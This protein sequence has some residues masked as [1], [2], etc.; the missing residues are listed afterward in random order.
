MLNPE[1]YRLLYPYIHTGRIWFNHAATGPLSSRVTDAIKQLLLMKSES[2]IDNFFDFTKTYIETKKLIATLLNCSPE[3]I[4]F[5]DNTSNGLNILASGLDWKP[6]DRILLNTVEFPSNVYPFLNLKSK[7]VEIDFVAERNGK[8]EI[9]DIVKAITP[10]TRLLSISF[11]QFLNGFKA[12]MEELGALC[13]KKNVLFCTDAIQGLGAAPL[14]VQK[15]QVDFL[16]SGTHKW[17]MGLQGFGFIYLTEELQQ[18]IH[19]AYLGWTSNKDF[20]GKFLEYYIHL[21]PTARR[22]ENGGLNIFS[23]QALR[24]SLSTLLEIGIE[25]IHEHLIYLT[26]RLSEGMRELGFES[27][28][29]SDS[30]ERAGIISFEVP[31]AEKNFKSLKDENIIV[32]SREGLLRVAPHYY[33]NDDDVER[34]L[35]VMSTIVRRR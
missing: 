25:Q 33:N 34:F 17:L 24:E 27:R 35:S 11:V 13:K 29:P 22:Y 1:K 8:I 5:V 30:K 10:R 21:D 31:D 26:D 3:R 18:H 4:A 6:G 2:E 16:S 9:D 20:F 28:T 23:I 32:S 19:Q 7:R 15:A 14:D 12:P